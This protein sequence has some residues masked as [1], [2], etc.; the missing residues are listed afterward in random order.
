M[1]QKGFTL[2]ELMIVVAIIAIIAAI[3]IP[4][5]LRARLS[6]NEASAI[7][8]LRTISSGQETFRSAIS[9]DQDTDGMGEY[10]NLKELAGITTP[11]SGTAPVNPPFIDDQLGV[12]NKSG[13]TFN[14]LLGSTACGGTAMTLTGPDAS[15]VEYA[16]VAWPASYSRTGNR[17]FFI[18]GSGVLRQTDRGTASV[19]SFGCTPITTAT[20]WPVV[21]G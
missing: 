12:G 6:A 9:K 17:S 21:G 15:E 4:N 7:A 3:A 16:A 18:D 10:G 13:Y 14:V 20:P 1:R 8:A 19:G 2:I 11:A 5:L